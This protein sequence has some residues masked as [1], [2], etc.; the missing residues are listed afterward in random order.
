MEELKINLYEIKDKELFSTCMNLY[1]VKTNARKAMLIESMNFKSENR[2]KNLDFIFSLVLK[3]NL[4]AIVENYEFGRYLVA[5]INNMVEYLN[6]LK[7]KNSDVALGNIL[8]FYCS[9][10][11][12]GNKEKERISVNINGNFPNHGVTNLIAFVCEKEKTNTEELKGHVEKIVNKI[13]RVLKEEIFYQ[14][15]EE[16]GY[17]ERVGM[18]RVWNIEYIN[19]NIGSYSDDIFNEWCPDSIL[20]KVFSEHIM[21]GDNSLQEFYYQ[22]WH[23]NFLNIGKILME[24]GYDGETVN[25]I[26]CKIDKDFF[27]SLKLKDVNINRLNSFLMHRNKKL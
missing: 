4:L 17:G 1:L 22:L 26:I 14:L 23:S 8:E 11:D 25:N 24:K 19:K 13:R 27:R 3:Y 9:D 5:N 18:L 20:G 10:H 15:N 6:E 7:I 12:Y 16:G 2:K 21:T